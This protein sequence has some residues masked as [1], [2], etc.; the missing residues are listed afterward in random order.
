[1]AESQNILWIILVSNF[2]PLLVLFFIA[3]IWRRQDEM[4][5]EIAGLG[6]ERIDGIDNRLDRQKKRHDEVVSEIHA[7]I[8]E[9]IQWHLDHP[10]NPGEGGSS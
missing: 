3:R 1:M 6:K 4:K 9:H 7:R 10:P 2:L 5:K 8:D